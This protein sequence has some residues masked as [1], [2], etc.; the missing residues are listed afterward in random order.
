MKKAMVLAVPLLC[1]AGGFAAAWA[2]RAPS[3]GPNATRCVAW[4]ACD[5]KPVE[6]GELRTS[7][8]GETFGVKDLLSAHAT[9]KPGMEPHPPHQHAEE[10]LLVLVEGEGTWILNGKEV[11]AKKGDVVYIAPWDMHG[12]KNTGTKPFVFYVAKWGYKGAQPEQK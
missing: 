12:M 11:P 10:E 8:Q 2:L 4:D 1:A 5:I 3:A 7:H 6:W 9:L